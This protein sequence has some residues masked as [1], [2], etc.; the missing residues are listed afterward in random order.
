MK[1]ADENDDGVLSFKG[2]L[3]IVIPSIWSSNNVI[4]IFVCKCLEFRTAVNMQHLKIDLLWSDGI[5]RLQSYSNRKIQDQTHHPLKINAR[6]LNNTL[7]PILSHNSRVIQD[8][9]ETKLRLKAERENN[10]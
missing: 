8:Q 10:I 4:V 6:F 7:R 9:Y 5:K 3:L 2:Q 1:L